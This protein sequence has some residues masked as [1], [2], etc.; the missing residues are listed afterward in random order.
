MSNNL[1]KSTTTVGCMTGISRI[2]GFVRDMVAAQLFGASA[3]YDAFLVAFK[4]PNF[5][6]MYTPKKVKN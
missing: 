5:M 3:G 2:L 6:R 1:A 4:I